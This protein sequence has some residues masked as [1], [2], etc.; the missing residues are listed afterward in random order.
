MFSTVLIANRGEIALRA[1]R[2]LKR[3][4]IRSIAVFA[5]PDRNSAHVR[6]ADTTI[7]L[8]GDKPADSYLRIDKLIAACQQSGAEAV[9]P[10]Y[11]FL[12]ESSEFAAACEAAGMIFLGPTPD[13]MRDFGLKHRARE[14]AAAA[15]VPLIP[16]T[17]LL[18]SLE[19]AL[20]Q[21]EHIGY[22]I[23]LKST[24]GGGGIGLSR[25]ETPDE[26]TAAYESAGRL[27]REFF[28]DGGTFLERYIGHARH[29]EVQMVGD[30]KGNV[31]AFGE[32]DCSV[33]RRNQKVIEE[34][35][36]PG[37]DEATRIALIA[38]ATRLCRSVNY[39]SAGAVEFLYDIARHSFYFLEVNTRLQVEHPVT[40]MVTGLDLIELMLRVGAGEALEWTVLNRAPR[41]AAMEVR[42]YAENPSRNF[43]PS[44]GT[45]TD[46]H[47]PPGARVD[48]WIDTGTEV[49]AY[50]DPLLAK[51][52]VHGPGR[53]AARSSLASAL[54]A[55]RLHGIATNLEYLRAIVADPR[56][57][58]GGVDTGFLDTFSFHPNA[59]EVLEPGIYT[60]VQDYPGRL[61]LWGIGVPPSG[62]M[63]DYAF[64]LANRIV[65]NSSEAAGLECTLAGPT[66]RFH[67]DSVVALTG[68]PSSA[69]L[70]GDPVPTWSPLHIKAGQTLTVGCV[71][72]GCRTYLAVR[73]GFDVPSYLGSRSTF[74]LGQFGGHAGRTL[75]AGDMLTIADPSLSA[76]TTP[77]P[78]DRPQATPT[79]LVPVYSAHW[80]ILVLHGPHGA[81][82]YFTHEAIEEF[83]A[84]EWEAHYNSNR[85]GVRLTGPKPSWS[86]DSG[87]EAGLHPSNVHDCVYA[88]GSINFTG[89]TPVILTRDGPSLGGFV[90]PATIASAELW[91]VGQIKPGD[92][93]HFTP[94]TLAQAAALETAQESRIRT[95]TAVPL[96][97]P[98]ATP[99]AVADAL[100]AGAILGSRAAEK[101]HPKAVWRQA[102]DNCILLEYGEDILDLAL[103]LRVYLLMETIRSEKLPILELSPGVRSLQI[104][105]H[106][107]RISQ[108][109]LMR[110]LYKIEDALPK[111]DSLRLPTRVVHLPMAFQD[112]ATLG[113][114][115]RYS[116]TVRCTAPWL[117]SNAEFLR[118]INGLGSVQEIRDIIFSARYMVLGLGDVYL[119]APCAVP[120]DPRHRLLSSKYN[121]ARTFTAEGTVGIGGMYMCIYGM[122]SPGGY[123]LVGRTLPIWNTFV[124]NPQFAPNEPW[125][126]RFFDQVRFY[127]VT[128][129]ELTVERESFREGRSS[130]RISEEIFEWAAYRQF[131]ELHAL[132]IA[133]FRVRQGAA[134]K[135]EVAHWMQTEPAPSPVSPAGTSLRARIPE[136]HQVLA[137]MHGSVRKVLVEPGDPVEVKQVLLII[138]AMKMEVAVLAP[139]AGVV[140]S[141][142]CKAGQTVSAGDILAV[143]Q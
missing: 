8:G 123:Q 135:T 7:A 141:T 10:G 32:R 25:C 90:C 109:G 46:V 104:R 3:L 117:P 98:Q 125:L 21:A 35:P 38:A 17:G 47:F 26:L 72:A 134:F 62:P 116:E 57:I 103:R 107:S 91:K 64:R 127:P 142:R 6:A 114:V 4:G 12:S 71:T 92:R 77:P 53:D 78:V 63:D 22:P 73:N 132:D 140:K 137:Q 39:R 115:A 52:I 36:A 24:A 93:I 112:S 102:G 97:S 68:A 61:G 30:G 94:I 85:L 49:T 105:Y 86:R 37:L 74:V 28:R 113:A 9:F 82:D 138:E 111:V 75:R 50:Y 58:S 106:A 29:I 59:V 13:Q 133:E 108:A 2:T 67:R 87:G 31:V 51:M 44:P 65:G 139:V 120:L 1:I 100:G 5:E 69:E 41:G 89:D 48:G 95:L 42:L 124:K 143:I 126:L 79:E 33:Q 43:Q 99:L 83:F 15:G 66:L 14:L 119:G 130:I 60:T 20:R 70:D 136:G 121:P 84:A 76:S 11:G 55:T 54:A 88:I 118:R 81:P 16:G 18:S 34:T 40:E 101:H 56:F 122:D 19:E 96:P 27:G 131:L 45:L 110:S 23:M 129:E 128:E 80:E